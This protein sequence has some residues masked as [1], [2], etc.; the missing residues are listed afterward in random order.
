M[1][2][3]IESICKVPC[4][5]SF[6]GLPTPYVPPPQTLLC[7]RSDPHC[8]SKIHGVF[9]DCAESEAF[10]VI[11][12]GHDLHFRWAKVTGPVTQRYDDLT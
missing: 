4:R 9:L 8:T 5:N 6:H 2:L 3:F 12:A 11:W 10:A 7:C 1:N